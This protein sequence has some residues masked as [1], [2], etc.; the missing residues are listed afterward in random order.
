MVA[1]AVLLPVT[2][3]AQVGATTDILTGVVVDASGAPVEG[4][5]IEARSLDLQVSRTAITD[6]RGR[7]T[8]LFP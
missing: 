7:Y 6:A 3:R 5:T 1:S 8:I 2:V 4:V